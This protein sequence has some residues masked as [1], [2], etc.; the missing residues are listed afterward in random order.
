MMK[1]YALA[2]TQ[3]DGKGGANRFVAYMVPKQV[4]QEQPAHPSNRHVRSVTCLAM[5]HDQQQLC[6]QAVVTKSTVVAGCFAPQHMSGALAARCMLSRGA[7]LNNVSD[8]CIL[9]HGMAGGSC[10]ADYS[11]SPGYKHRAA[12]QCLVPG[13]TQMLAS[14]R[15][16]TNGS[17]STYMM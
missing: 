14:W 12:V 11:C 5:Q 4:P 8:L 16:S 15:E 1:S 13:R 3:P 17:E 6:T 9:L 7:D 2:S 10:I